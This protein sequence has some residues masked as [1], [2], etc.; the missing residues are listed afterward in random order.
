[1]TYELY[2]V[3]D[4]DG[5][6]SGELAYLAGKL[7]GVRD[8]ALCDISHGWNPLGKR[9]WRVAQRQTSQRTF[10][11]TWLHRDEQPPAMSSLTNGKLPAVILRLQGHYQILLSKS[12]LAACDGDLKQFEIALARKLES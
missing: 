12:E 1:M 10:Q 9:A 4:A 5:S 11:I 6:L 8:C 7:M 2:A 3:Y